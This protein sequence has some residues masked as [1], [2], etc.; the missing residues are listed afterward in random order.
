M[1]PRDEII[2]RMAK[3]IMRSFCDKWR[4]HLCYPGKGLML[5]YIN[6]SA[7]WAEEAEAA[8]TASGLEGGMDNKAAKWI[9]EELLPKL[10]EAASRGLD[11]DDSVVMQAA[12]LGRGAYCESLIDFIATNRDKWKE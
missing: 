11:G 12:G 4:K 8:L 1:T 6:G 2:E 5:D 10:Q 7:V 3:E 9:E